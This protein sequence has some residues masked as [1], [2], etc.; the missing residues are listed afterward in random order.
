MNHVSAGHCRGHCCAASQRLGVLLLGADCR[1]LDMDCGPATPCPTCVQGS[2]I[3][4]GSLFNGLQGELEGV[5][6]QLATSSK[7]V[8][9]LDGEL[10][11]ARSDVTNLKSRVSE[12]M[13]QVSV[14]TSARMS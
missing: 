5:K 10:A 9:R 6:T 11:A 4:Q 8:Q 13:A 2:I 1:Q 7:E 3:C 12:L 14:R